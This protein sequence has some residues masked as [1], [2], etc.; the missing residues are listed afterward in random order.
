M[1]FFI[2]LSFL[3]SQTSGT[4]PKPEIREKNNIA[5]EKIKETPSKSESNI[6]SRNRTAAVTGGILF[7]PTFAT[8][9]G[10]QLWE[11]GDQTH[12]KASSDGWFSS[13]TTH[14]GADKLG[15]AWSFFVGTKMFTYYFDHV[16]PENHTKA[17]IMGALLSSLGG[18]AVEIGDGFATDY[19][20]SY[21][22]IV[23]NSLGVLIALGQ[24]LFPWFDNLVDFSLYLFP[25]PGFTSSKNKN[26]T[27]IATDYSGQLATINIRLGG[28]PIVKDT[29]LRYFRFDFGYFTRCYQPYD[30]CSKEISG[31]SEF[32]SRNIYFGFSFDFARMISEKY[33]KTTGQ[34]FLVNMLRVVNLN[35][36]FPVGFNVDLNK[37]GR[38]S[39][40]TQTANPVNP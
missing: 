39:F 38:V 34:K 9:V 15:H 37:N 2:I 16:F 5:V 23:F 14:G 11:W 20:F 21:T 1:Y 22:D 4:P 8:L 17:A 3:Y 40:G 18:I 12:F 7:V 26:K 24:E 33:Y 19:G 36:A 29:F 30:A 25:S 35:G 31:V 10:M 32:E 13:K 28:I 27:D 6:L